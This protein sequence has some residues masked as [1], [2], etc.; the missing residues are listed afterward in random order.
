MRLNAQYVVLFKIPRDATEVSHL[1]MQIYPG[2][3]R[4]MQEAF[5]DA[6]SLP[7]GYLLVDL[8]QETPEHG[9]RVFS[10]RTPF[11]TSICRDDKR[12]ERVTRHALCLQLLA[13]HK[14]GTLKRAFIA[15]ADS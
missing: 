13:R 14:N 12:S 3:V 7:Y 8:K 15:N 1:A 9:G 6:T 5:K 11:S 2:R 4:Y 10:Q